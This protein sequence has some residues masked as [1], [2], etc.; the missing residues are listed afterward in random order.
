MSVLNQNLSDDWQ[1]AIEVSTEQKVEIIRVSIVGGGSINDARRLETSVGTYFAKIN[2]AT[3]YPG[4]FD[5]EAT[6]LNF[7][8]ANCQFRIPQPIATGIT[9][10]I[11]W[12]LMEN[13]NSTNRK[14]DFWEEFGR[15]LADMHK[16]SADYFGFG[17]NNYLGSLIQ[18]NDK[19]ETWESFFTDM[20]INPQLEMAKQNGLATSEFLRLFEKMLSRVERYFPKEP[21]AAVHGDLWTGNFMTDSHGEA[22]IFDPAV[23]YGHREMDLGMSKLFGGFDKRF[24]DAYNEVYPLESGWEERIH[25]ANLYPLL[26]HV[27]LFGGSYTG[28]VIQI[29]RRHI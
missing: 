27:N 10:E 26:A 11:Q 15:K 18:K 5:A 20:R 28:Q 4:M 1:K 14:P 19:R 3:E 25:V 13:I 22:V 8:K 7:L 17:E 24:Y 23:Y 6:G 21:P 16:H 9:E 2:S 12:I 29:L